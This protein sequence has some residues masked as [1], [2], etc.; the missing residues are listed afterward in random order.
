MRSFALPAPKARGMGGWSSKAEP[1]PLFGQ[2]PVVFGCFAIGE[3]PNLG[4]SKNAIRAG[5]WLPGGHI[6]AHIRV[7]PCIMRARTIL[8]KRRVPP[9]DIKS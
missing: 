9:F 6:R 8:P 2:I 5:I 4:V 3:G 1:S 7:C